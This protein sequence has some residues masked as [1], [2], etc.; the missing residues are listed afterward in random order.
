MFAFNPL[1]PKAELA[2]EQPGFNDI[3]I[4][5]DFRRRAIAY[6]DRVS[7]ASEIKKLEISA[8]KGATSFFGAVNDII[9]GVAQQGITYIWNAE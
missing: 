4:R 2:Y 3:I 7:P 1:V 8:T 6:I 5:N 9:A